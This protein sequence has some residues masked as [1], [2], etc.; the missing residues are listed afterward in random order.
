MKVLVTGAN[1]SIGRA[2]ARPPRR[3]LPGLGLPGLGHE[4]RGLDLTGPDDDEAATSFALGWVTGD[5][6]DPE[7]VDGAVEG[8]DAVVHLA[9]NPDE[10]SL[11][12]CLESHVHT[13]ARL[14]EAMVRHG[15]G[16]IAYASSNHAVGLTPRG[17]GELTTKVRPRPDM[18]Y[19][20]AKVAAESLLSLYADRH[21]M[22]AVAMRIGSF[23]QAPR[24]VRQ[25]STWLSPDDAVRMVDAAISWNQPGLQV[26]H[27]ISA[28]TRGWWDLSPGRAIGFE[29]RDDAERFVDSVPSSPADEIEDAFVGGPHTT[30]AYSRAAF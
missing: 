3:G 18:F 30:T 8:V 21:D 7:V 19:G 15:V 26:V 1:G 13:T 4:L 29:P 5:C 2:L 11:P 23:Q 14:L 17:N 9:G 28:N 25:L 16:T 10:D 24:S 20:V 6:L 22:V 27:G 12:A